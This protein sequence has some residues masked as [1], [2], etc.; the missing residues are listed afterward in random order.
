MLILSTYIFLIYFAVMNLE[1]K[2]KNNKL[3][4]SSKKI[5]I[6]WT[7]FYSLK[8]KLHNLIYLELI[9]QQSIKIVDFN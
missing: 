2:R 3:V 8:A 5:I 4:Y 9:M 1:M 7:N 6:I